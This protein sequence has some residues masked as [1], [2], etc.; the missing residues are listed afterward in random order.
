[1][2]R[3]QETTSLR[4]WGGAAENFSIRKDHPARRVGAL[5]R[6]PTKPFASDV[7]SSIFFGVTA[8]AP[9]AMYL[10]ERPNLRLSAICCTGL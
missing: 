2:G 10:F 9:Q 5:E 8:D 4:S 7:P 1:M 6:A 3:C